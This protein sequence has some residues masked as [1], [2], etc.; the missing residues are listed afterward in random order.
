MLVFKQWGL[1][2]RYLDIKYL[3]VITGNPDR[4]YFN[5][6]L[7]RDRITGEITGMAPNYDNNFAFM[8]HDLETGSFVKAAALY[9]WQK[10]RITEK[11]L[12]DVLEEMTSL[13]GF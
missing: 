13:S 7:L 1:D 2:G 8:A 3:D 4:H 6:D 12:G 5:Y 10:P 9:D 11:L